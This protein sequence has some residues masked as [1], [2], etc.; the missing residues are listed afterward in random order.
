MPTRRQE[1][2]NA[3]IVTEVAEGL[4]GIKDPRLGFVTVLSA[5]VSPDLRHARVR[6]SVFTADPELKKVNLG[7]VRHHAGAMR[8][9]LAKSL[10]GRTV[11]MLHFELDESVGV[12]DEMSRLIRDARATDPNPG[13]PTPEQ[14]ALLDAAAAA[15]VPAAAPAVESWSA[16]AAAPW[17]EIDA[18]PL[19]EN[20]DDEDEDKPGG[21]KDWPVPE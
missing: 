9:R 8:A 4:R 11:P 5:E 10:G 18:A 16:P 1:R 3:R 7:L 20:A 13:A 21:A 17:G 6:F 14:Q 15:A 12:A 19:G 2:I